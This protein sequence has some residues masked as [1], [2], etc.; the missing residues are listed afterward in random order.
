MDEPTIRTCP[1][2]VRTPVCFIISLYF[3]SIS[4][5]LKQTRRL[6]KAQTTHTLP[7]DSYNYNNE[8]DKIK[9]IPTSTYINFQ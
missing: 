5:P 9:L 3:R 2:I 8:I 7:A 4:L 6:H 1:L